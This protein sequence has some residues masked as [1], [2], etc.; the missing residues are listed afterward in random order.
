MR[1][2]TDCENLACGQ[3]SHP[4]YYNFACD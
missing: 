4:S 1:Q 2:M 3:C